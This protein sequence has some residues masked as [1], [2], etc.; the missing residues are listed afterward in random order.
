MSKPAGSVAAPV[1]LWERAVAG[2]YL[3]ARR[4]H[5]GVALISLI[6]FIGIMLA[7]M[8][9]IVVMSVMNGFRTELLDR[10]LG[11]KGHAYVT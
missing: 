2:R 7:V 11:F 1:G 5:G 3:R 8:V 4:K 6:S 10:I 9:L